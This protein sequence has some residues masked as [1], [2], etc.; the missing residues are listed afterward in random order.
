ML[1]SEV[2]L[3]KAV[4]NHTAYALGVGPEVGIAG[5]IPYW[6]VALQHTGW[7]GSL[8]FGVSG[9]ID[10]PYPAGFTHGPTDDITDLG[11]DSQYQWITPNQAYSLQASY[12]HESQH[13]G[14]SYPLGA[15]ANLNDGL[16]TETL[17]AS[18]LAYQA[19]GATESFTNITGTGDAVLYAAAPIG[20]NAN[21]KPNTESFTTELDYYPFDRGGPKFFRWANA[22]FFI[23]GTVYPQFNG[24][25]RNYDGSGRS[26]AANDVLFTGIWLVF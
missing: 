11:V 16:D 26:A 25:A 1:Y 9:L 17:T 20:G 12:F 13:W 3:Y 4:P 21:G 10:H 8:E 6:R 5:V 18:Y 15:T 14:A 23:E 2:D 19:F 22:K 7:K 24:L